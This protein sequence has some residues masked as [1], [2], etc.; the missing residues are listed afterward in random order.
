MT[1][2]FEPK[3][4]TKLL[5]KGL[6]DRNRNVVLERFG[7]GA[8]AGRKT[9]EAIGGNYGITRERVRQI[10]NYALNAIR[11]DAAFKEAKG[12]F[13]ELAGIIGRK[14]WVVSEENIFNSLTDDA[15]TKNHLHFLF[16]LGDDFVKM[17]EDEEFCHR[18]ALNEETREMVHEVLKRMHERV[19]EDDLIPENEI[20][21]EFKK[22]AYT[23]M[24]RRVNEEAIR[25]WL[26]VS[27]VLGRNA[28][29]QWG[30]AR[31][32]NIRPRGM[33]DLAFLVLRKHGS[34]MHFSEVAEAISE[35]FA[36]GAHPATVH[37]ELI[38]DERFILVG[39]G[40]Y[41]LEGWG[42]RPGIVREVIRKILESEKA[43]SREE[44][45]R[46][47]LK[48]RYVKENTILVN[49]QNNKYF[50]R[51]PAGKYIIA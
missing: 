46:R 10:E 48:E 6:K 34:P 32:A 23:V 9:L 45:V 4:I 25:S 26:D 12:V 40:L 31:S 27:K 39:R 3:S 28:T 14:G 8:S 51:T 2:S 24:R 42:Y 1:I 50:K 38:K 20:I 36:R 21:S 41:A 17:K 47:V 18:W 13:S 22:Q 33:R 37:N 30:R 44:I 19:K 5:V 35:F 16:V 49:L 29:G 7:L 43:L 11:R 15:R